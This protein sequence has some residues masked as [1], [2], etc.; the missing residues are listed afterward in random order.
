MKNCVRSNVREHRDMKNN[1]NYIAMDISLKFDNP[2][3]M[4]II[5][6]E[7]KYYLRRSCNGLIIYLGLK[8][9]RRSKMFKRRSMP[10]LQ[11]VLRIFLI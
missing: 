2:N 5:Y 1:E 3:K 10:L 7:P 6:L 9:I 4:K 8:A 11:S